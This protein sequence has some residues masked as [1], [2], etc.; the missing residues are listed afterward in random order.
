M[1]NLCKHIFTLLGG[2][3]GWLLAEFQPT[4]PLIIV[5][6]IFIVYDAYTAFRLEKRVCAKYPDKA[7]QSKFSSYAFGKLVRSTIPSRLVLIILAFLVEKW[8]FTFV[9]V[10]LSYIVTGII[11]FEQAWSIM[12]NESSCRDEAESMFWKLLQKVMIDK[13]ARHFDVNLDDLNGKKESSQ[14]TP[15]A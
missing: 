9:S 8:V 1:D 4:F 13:T 12:E 5:A 2:A 3:A 14:P 6:T 15:N 11:C 7:R 10:P